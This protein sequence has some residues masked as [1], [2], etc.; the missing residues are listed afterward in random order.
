MRKPIIAGNWK[1]NKTLTETKSFVDEVKGLIPDGNRVD[2]VVCA[3]AL[4]LDYLTDELEGTALQVGAQNMHFEENGAFTG[5]ISPVALNDLGV[6]Y[7]ILGHSERRELF[8]ETD[9]I[10]NQ[11]TH[12]AFKHNLTPI[13]C[14]GETLEQRESDVTEDIV[15]AQVQ[16]AIAGLTNEQVAQS[17]IAY[18]PIW[19]IGTGKTATSDQANDVCAFIRGV[20][21][22]ETSDETANAVRIQYGGS[23]KPGNIDELMGKSDIDGALVG[24]ASL[25]AKSFLQLLEAGQNA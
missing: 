16:K 20:L 22:D 18:E 23:V 15:K 8:G 9:E 2:S 17:V 12:A 4:F 3:P 21:K 14:V 25:D 10:V 6:G 5:E 24:G 19:A 11:K 13:I 7:V 1:M